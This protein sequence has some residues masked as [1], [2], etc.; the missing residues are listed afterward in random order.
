MSH[1]IR[2]EVHKLADQLP[3]DADWDDVMYQVYVRLKIAEG[4]RDGDEGR[5]LPHEEIKKR[6]RVSCRSSGRNARSP[7]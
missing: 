3:P 4:L 6:F 2:E 7:T 1:S 5:V